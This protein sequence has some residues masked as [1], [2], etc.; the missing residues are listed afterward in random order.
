MKTMTDEYIKR[1]DALKT[2]RYY[3]NQR[4]EN[5]VPSVDIHLT[6][7]Q[8]L[9][10]AINSI[11]AANVEP[12]VR[13]ENCQF[14]EIVEYWPD[15]TKKVCQLLKRQVQ[16]NSFCCWGMKKEAEDG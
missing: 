12:V 5:H 8:L 4:E 1:S 6:E 9:A 10:Q 2:A 14:F 11:P 7:Y 3:K 16:E 15:G 13:C